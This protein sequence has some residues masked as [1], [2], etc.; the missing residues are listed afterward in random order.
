MN[1]IW[2]GSRRFMG[3]NRVGL[4][5]FLEKIDKISKPVFT[6][7]ICH[8]PIRYPFNSPR[9]ASDALSKLQIVGGGFRAK[10]QC[11]FCFANDRLR[12]TVEVLKKHTSIL[13]K[14]CDVL[15]FAPIAGMKTFLCQN[16]DC[17]YTSGDIVPGRA[18]HVMDI[19]HIDFPDNSFDYVI[20]CHVLEHIERE[21][22]AMAEMMRVLK[23]GGCILLSFPISLTSPH[24]FTDE[25]VKTDEDRLRVYGQNDH[26]RL[27]GLDAGQHLA[28]YGLDI[29][30]FIA[31]EDVPELVAPYKLIPDD[32][33]FLCWKR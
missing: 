28:Q 4:I 7:N 15:E 18:E 24:T 3:K 13:S 32:R 31:K 33:N 12:F 26:V 1:R 25:S 29:Q 11:P 17:H 5:R 16:K 23:P 8:R 2:T 10:Q 6:C 19:T 22:L 27:Y 20:C 9:H 14:P 21:E 30:A